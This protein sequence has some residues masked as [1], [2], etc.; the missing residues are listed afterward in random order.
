[1]VIAGEWQLS[2]DGVT[3]P[4]LHAR[5]HKGDG[6]L[7]AEDFL[8]DSGADRTAF[9]TGLLE[10][11][12]IL[13]RKPPVDIALSGIGGVSAFVLVTT[14][15]ELLRVDGSPVRVRGEFAGF[16]DPAATDLSVLGRDVLDNFDLILSRPRNEILLLAPRHQY[17]VEQT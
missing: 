16:T 17:R 11:L 9:R 13:T 6:T 15:I 1:M 3:R 7:I 8:I 4:I 12:Q 10:Q 14:V 2:D 5:I